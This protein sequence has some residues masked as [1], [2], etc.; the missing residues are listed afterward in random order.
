MQSICVLMDIFII[1]MV[2]KL[3]LLR[4]DVGS[5]IKFI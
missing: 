5:K 1:N 4:G 3:C 2:N